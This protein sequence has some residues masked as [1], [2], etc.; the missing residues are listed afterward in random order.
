MFNASSRSRGRLMAARSPS[1]IHHFHIFHQL[2]HREPLVIQLL[3]TGPQIAKLRLRCSSKPRIQ[4]FP[5]KHLQTGTNSSLSCRCHIRKPRKDFGA[6]P[7]Q[8]RCTLPKNS[9]NTTLPTTSE[10][11]ILAAIRSSSNKNKKERE[12]RHKKSSNNSSLSKT[13]THPY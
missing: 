8:P 5:N 3:N 6:T 12:D 10:L 11:D 13:S 2:G 9:G 7:R 4:H 1:P